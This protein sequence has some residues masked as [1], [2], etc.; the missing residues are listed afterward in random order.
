MRI[1]VRRTAAD[2]HSSDRLGPVSRISILEFRKCS[3][4]SSGT[5]LRHNNA[6]HEPNVRDKYERWNGAHVYSRAGRTN[7]GRAT[8]FNGS[9]CFPGHYRQYPDFHRARP[10]G[11]RISSE[12][13]REPPLLYLLHTEDGRNSRSGGIPCR[14][15]K[16]ERSGQARGRH[17]GHPASGS[18]AQRR[19][20]CIWA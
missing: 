7:L 4:S 14:G 3:G 12:L 18:R 13:C 16:C 9:E 17:P 15:F 2:A 6:P 5:S 1:G 20:A 10:S 11:T 19:H 8:G